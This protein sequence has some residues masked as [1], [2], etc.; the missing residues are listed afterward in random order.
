MRRGSTG[1]PT[2][3]YFSRSSGP[4]SKPSLVTVGIT[5][6]IGSWNEVLWP[7]IVIR[8]WDMMTM[9]QMV[10]LFSVGGLAGAQVAAEMA[11]ATMLRCLL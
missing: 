11:A 6:F 7:L 5:T 2:T 9:P 4:L 8:K 10:T 1:A 3:R